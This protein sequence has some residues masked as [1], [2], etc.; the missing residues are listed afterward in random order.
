MGSLPLISVPMLLEVHIPLSP[1]I[2]AWALVASGI[3]TKPK[4]RE[5]PL[6]RHVAIWARSTVP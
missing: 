4:P 2:A 3:S 5:R 1:A 6:S